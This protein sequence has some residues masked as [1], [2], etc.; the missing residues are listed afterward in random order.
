[1]KYSSRQGLWKK[2]RL[3]TQL[4]FSLR[5]FEDVAPDQFE[6]G[7]GAG[8]PGAAKSL[9]KK[10]FLP[11]ILPAAIAFLVIHPYISPIPHSRTTGNRSVVSFSIPSL[12]FFSRIF[13][14]NHFSPDHRHL[15]S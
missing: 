6:R 15:A 9:H 3:R 10:L 7:P 5:T 13:N 2:K 1:M 11:T 14:Y 12:S 4:I 8:T